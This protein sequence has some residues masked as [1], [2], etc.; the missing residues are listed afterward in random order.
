MVRIDQHERIGAIDS[1]LLGDDIGRCLG[2]LAMS[3]NI[4]LVESG[5][6]SLSL[7]STISKELAASSAA[8]PSAIPA[9]ME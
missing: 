1:R 4:G 5:I 9:A 6:E 3:S 7:Q 2:F 8:M